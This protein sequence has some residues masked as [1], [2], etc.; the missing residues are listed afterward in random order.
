MERD[1]PLER[2]RTDLATL[3][4][5]LYRELSAFRRAIHPARSLHETTVEELMVLIAA[6]MG[7]C[8]RDMASKNSPIVDSPDL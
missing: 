5:E 3:V 8:E 1:I 2:F 6:L 7:E 4:G